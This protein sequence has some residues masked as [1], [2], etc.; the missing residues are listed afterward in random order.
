MRRRTASHNVKKG[1]ERRLRAR[2]SKEVCLALARGRRMI[3]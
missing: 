3:D 2:A 1:T